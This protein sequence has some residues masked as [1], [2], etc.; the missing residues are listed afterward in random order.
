MTVFNQPFDGAECDVG[1]D[2]A[3]GPNDSGSN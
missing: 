2:K 1:G 3:S